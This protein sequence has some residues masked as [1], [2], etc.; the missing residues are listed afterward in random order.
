LSKIEAAISKVDY[1]FYATDSRGEKIPQ[2]SNPSIISSMLNLLD[3][4]EGDSVLEI[5]T[6]SGY[7]TAL[8][9]NLVG[10]TGKIVSIDIVPELVTRASSIFTEQGLEYVKVMQGDGRKGAIHEGPFDRIILWAT[11]ACI[12]SE[13]IEQLSSDGI[14]VAPINL[15]PL[16]G[17]TVVVRLK[18]SDG[19]LI[20]ERITPGGFVNLSNEPQQQWMGPFDGADVLIEDNNEPELGVSSMWLK[21]LEIE[22]RKKMINKLFSMNITQKNAFNSDEDMNDLRVFLLAKNPIGLSTLFSKQHG[23]SIGF[24]QH[25]GFAFISLKTGACIYCG[26]PKAMDV[27][28]AWIREWRNSG[29]P[30][31]EQVT[32]YADQMKGGW[33]INLKV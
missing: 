25:D 33:R 15:L 27:L 13:L 19:I 1:Y 4:N 18:R 24:S 28:K 11:A 29:R 14:M 26:N 17:S 16:L 3:V 23:S 9:A 30:G 21:A 12:H 6:G 8:L 5:G 2:T 20:G 22:E 32:P 10:S 7:S 31:F